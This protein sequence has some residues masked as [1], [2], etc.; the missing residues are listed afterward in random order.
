M[1]LTDIPL[2]DHSFR[3]GIIRTV[4]LDADGRPYVLDDDGSP[5]YGVW[6]LLADNAD[7]AV[8]QPIIRTSWQP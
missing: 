5:A 4:R 8:D 7:D 1:M 6:I 2:G 3:A